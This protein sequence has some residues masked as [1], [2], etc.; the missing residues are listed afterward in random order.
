[1]KLGRM[2]VEQQ[3]LVAALDE[4]WV[5]SGVRAVCQRCW[6]GKLHGYSGR[7]QSCC[8][9]WCKSLT[10]NGC[11]AKPTGCAIYACRRANRATRIAGKGPADL[12]DEIWDAANPTCG[13][14]WTVYSSGYARESHF[15][16][17]PWMMKRY[18]FMLRH[19]RALVDRLEGARC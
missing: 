7:S 13:G 14:T 2:P 11:V 10:P 9:P 17:L 6:Q 12:I 16:H 8:P 5:K 4:F 1:M 18:Y 3:L 15:S 19:V